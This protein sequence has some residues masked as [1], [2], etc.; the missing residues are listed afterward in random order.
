VAI[1]K[2]E[3]QD[4]PH[5]VDIHVGSR[6]RLFRAQN[7]LSQVELAEKVGV[8]FQAI[9][10]YETGEIRISASRLYEVAQV[11]GVT[12]GSLFD[13]YGASAL[14][15]RAGT[16]ASAGGDGFDRR[17]VMAL[18]RAYYGIR[19]KQLQRDVL[20]LITHMGQHGAGEQTPENS[21][22]D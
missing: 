19:D 17:E 16:K 4:S 6:I 14:I 22:A 11:L 3:K 5:P 10:K 20:R 7:R 21:P 18:M 2:T 8:S 15:E 13:E 9:Q 1:E 12:P